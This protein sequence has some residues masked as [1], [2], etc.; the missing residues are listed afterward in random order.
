MGLTSSQK[1]PQH[2]LTVSYL[3]SSKCQLFKNIAHDGSHKFPKAPATPPHSI[4]FDMDG[5]DGM[6]IS[7]DVHRSDSIEH[8]RC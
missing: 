7:I 6:E 2:L 4:I 3:I 1:L 8:L 5:L